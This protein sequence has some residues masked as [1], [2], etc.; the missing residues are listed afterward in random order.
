MD[1]KSSVQEPES[2]EKKLLLLDLRRI[3][4]LAPLGLLLTFALLATMHFSKRDLTLEG[5]SLIDFKN[6]FFGQI[7]ADAVNIVP[8]DSDPLTW[9]L[10]FLTFDV[11]IVVVIV[12]DGKSRIKGT[13]E[14]FSSASIGTS[15]VILFLTGMLSPCLMDRNGTFIGLVSILF[16]SVW[17]CI[18]ANASR[19]LTEEERI[20]LVTEEQKKKLESDATA[21][22]ERLSN[23][24]DSRFG[25]KTNIKWFQRLKAPVLLVFVPYFLVLAAF[26]AAVP[27]SV[28]KE[29]SVPLFIY[30]VRA[31]GQVSIMQIVGFICQFLCCVLICSSAITAILVPMLLDVVVGT[32]TQPFF[33]KVEQIVWLMIV[34]F[35]IPVVHL[36]VLCSLWS[37]WPKFLSASGIVL[38][39]AL[40]VICL[41]SLFL[42]S[43]PWFCTSKKNS[44]CYWINK[45]FDCYR[46][47]SFH[48]SLRRITENLQRMEDF[49][50]AT[51][52][53]GL[54]RKEI[55][56]EDLANA[57]ALDVEQSLDE[58]LAVL[59]R[60]TAALLNATQRLELSTSRM[61]KKNSVRCLFS[62]FNSADRSSGV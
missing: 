3:I 1:E 44:L 13:I 50:S 31:L 30:F 35:Y 22:R 6:S 46:H 17:A 55:Q 45:L 41:C 59:E 21:L 57:P 47:Y 51:P 38:T 10:T 14:L 36:G 24:I 2:V 49:G 18:L 15:I 42:I 8:E 11:A 4:W 53:F 37:P 33:R 25:E 48:K 23:G 62:R 52:V 39:I 40:V 7:W 61:K 28:E 60:Q 29:V 5:S 12:M 16:I 54:K 34:S 58:R 19:I 9:L 43:L 26:F 32:E 20:T 56:D 27:A